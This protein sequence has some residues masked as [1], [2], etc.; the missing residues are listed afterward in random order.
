MAAIVLKP[1][2]TY[3]NLQD[4]VGG[5]GYRFGNQTDYSNV[6]SY[7][8]PG[9]GYHRTDMTGER[10]MYCFG[11]TEDAVPYWPIDNRLRMHCDMGHGASGGPMFI[12]A[13]NYNPQ[14]I[15]ANSHFE[16][17]ATTG[18]RID[19]SLF[20]SLHDANAVAV[21]NNANGTA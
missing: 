5:L 7:G 19:D 2:A 15:G 9:D 6:F 1:D 17:D 13:M 10:M 3:G 20:S 21:I 18:Q 8:Y 12:G 11:N 16:S 14:I 4:K